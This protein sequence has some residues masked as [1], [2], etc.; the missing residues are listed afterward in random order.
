[1]LEFALYIV[2]PFIAI[3]I[4]IMFIAAIKTYNR[5]CTD[6]IYREINTNLLYTTAMVQIFIM[7]QVK[8]KDK[9]EEALKYSKGFLLRSTQDLKGDVYKSKKHKIKKDSDRVVIDNAYKSFAILSDILLFLDKVN[10]ENE[11]KIFNSHF[12]Y[13]TSIAITKGKEALALK[14]ENK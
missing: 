10:T 13:A 7:A 3:F 6:A 12:E 4:I 1:M 11:I 2:S 8:F 14:K 9:E 5:E